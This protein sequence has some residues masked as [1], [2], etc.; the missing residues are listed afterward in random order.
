MPSRTQFTLAVV[1]LVVV[2]GCSA[3][4]DGGAGADQTT[5]DSPNHH[6]LLFASETGGYEY[7]ATV[8]V[9]R[10]GEQLLLETV[11]SDGD[12]LYTDL[13]AIDEPGPYT[14]TVN[15]TLPEAGGGNQRVQ[16]ETTGDLGNATAITVDYQDVKYATFELPRRD[17]TH[18]LGLKSHY[19]TVEG[20]QSRDLELRVAYRGEHLVSE[21]VT[22]E[23]NKLTRSVSLEGIG[24]YHVAA[25]VDG[26]WVNETVVVTTP[27]EHVA[28]V[29]NEHG[30]DATIRV[31]RPFQWN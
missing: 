28:V 27:D 11:S 4:P 6:E 23:G 14:V 10:D 7:E 15:T 24:V 21:T 13:A 16:F 5:V 2:S 1:A 25:R 19:A 22:V 3:L 18:E 26:T 30:D 8:K 17:L 12:G 9:E 20:T 29:V 31:Q